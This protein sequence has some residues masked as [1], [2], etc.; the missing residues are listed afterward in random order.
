MGTYHAGSGSLNNAGKCEVVIN[1]T[2]G[3]E[4]IYNFLMSSMLYFKN[5]K[6]WTGKKTF[7]VQTHANIGSIY[8]KWYSLGI[9]DNDVLHVLRHWKLGST[10]GRMYTLHYNFTT[11]NQ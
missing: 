5:T 3:W 11:D 6:K 7:T 1:L 2:I 4:Y 8:I 10:L 9:C